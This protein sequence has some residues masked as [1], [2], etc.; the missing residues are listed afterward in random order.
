MEEKYK[1][2]FKN[3]LSLTYKES[4][5]NF[6]KGKR[7]RHKKRVRRLNSWGVGCPWSAEV[8]RIELCWENKLFEQANFSLHWVSVRKIKGKEKEHYLKYFELDNSPLVGAETLELRHL[9]CYLDTY[10][11]ENFFL[12]PEKPQINN[13]FIFPAKKIGDK[14][15]RQPIARRIWNKKNFKVEPITKNLLTVYLST[16][17]HQNEDFNNY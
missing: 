2:A 7:K 5:K 1:L 17:Y 10:Y 4:S 15:I 3:P 13:A 9:L 16:I 12:K 6:R 11:Q 8:F 14:A